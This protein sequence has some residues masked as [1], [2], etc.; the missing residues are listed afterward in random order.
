MIHICILLLIVQK[1]QEE[2]LKEYKKMKQV[3]SC[4]NLWSIQKAHLIMN[5]FVKHS[6]SCCVQC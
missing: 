3:S 2:V 4:I 1:V 6:R 5:L